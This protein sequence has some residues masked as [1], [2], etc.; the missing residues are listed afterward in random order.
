MATDIEYYIVRVDKDKCQ[1]YCQLFPNGPKRYFNNIEEVGSNY[2]VLSDN[3]GEEKRVGYECLMPRIAEKAFPEWA[4]ALCDCLGECRTSDPRDDDGTEPTEPE[5]VLQGIVTACHVDDPKTPVRL[6]VFSNPNCLALDINGEQEVN[7]DNYIMST[8]KFGR[9][10]IKPLEIFND[11][12]SQLVIRT[13]G[14]GADQ[15]PILVGAALI[16]AHAAA[17]TEKA[18]LQEGETIAPLCVAVKQIPDKRVITDDI[19]GADATVKNEEQ[20]VTTNTIV[21]GTDE[22]KLVVGDSAL[23]Y[24]VNPVD[25]GNCVGKIDPDCAFQ[26]G[27][28]LVNAP[29]DA[30]YE[31]CI[32][33]GCFGA[34]EEEGEG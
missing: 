32:T 33:F 20:I 25:D 23:E 22:D 18:N 21:G 7:P 4:Q 19:A 27:W 15:D 29:V 28:L 26:E 24:G 12:K 3:D 2:V 8:E 9:R 17:L 10:P 1:P 31:L 16:A 11:Y 5:K 13:I 30:G 14:T 34:A 6:Y